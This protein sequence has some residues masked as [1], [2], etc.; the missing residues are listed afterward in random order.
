[1]EWSKQV[2]TASPLGQTIM[3]Q[4]MK[5]VKCKLTEKLGNV[6]IVEVDA[7]HVVPIRKILYYN[8]TLLSFRGKYAK[9]NGKANKILDGL[10]I[11]LG[12]VQHEQ[13]RQQWAKA[14][15]EN[16][17]SCYDR[18]QEHCTQQKSVGY[19]KAKLTGIADITNS[20]FQ[21]HYSSLDTGQQI[22][23]TNGKQVKAEAIV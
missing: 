8:R 23:S 19:T 13:I 11:S 20:E 22:N 1:M 3:T 17:H 6:T 2:W 14:I 15:A 9:I 7:T 12:Q 10:P 5:V 21:G 16:D 18:D 4:V